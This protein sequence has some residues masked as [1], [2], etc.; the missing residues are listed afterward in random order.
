MMTHLSPEIRPTLKLAIPL[1]IAFLGQQLITIVDTFVSGQLGVEVLAAV[2]LGNALYWMVTIFPIGLLMGLDPIISQALG[3]RQYAL[4]WRACRRGIGLALILSTLTTAVLMISAIEGWP[5][6]PS[7]PVSEHLSAYIWGRAWCVPLVLM[8]TCLRS[9]L[10]AHERGGVILVGTVISNILNLSLSVYLS[11]GDALFSRIFGW[12]SLET[13]FA[14]WGT[15]GIGIASTIVLAVDVSFLSWVAWRMQRPSST[16]SVL[17]DQ[18]EDHDQESIPSLINAWRS[19]C[20]IGA[21]IGG[22]MLSEGGVFCLSTLLVSV[23]STVSIGAHQIVLQLCSTSFMICLGIA[24][25]TCVRVGLAFGAQDRIRA[26]ATALVGLSLSIM[27]MLCSA[28]IFMTWGRELAGILTIDQEVISLCVKLLWIVVI[29]QIFDGIQTTVAAALRGAGY[30]RVPLISA[31]ISHW[32][33]GLPLGLYL[34]F[35]LKLE[36]VGIWW[37]LSG[38]LICAAIILTS[39][40]FWLT[41]AR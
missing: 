5:W 24:S 36:V 31:V 41:R 39:S 7:G 18:T 16:H 13:G 22:S 14:G 28:I 38:G 12:N 23:W 20:R 21:P 19:L 8:H 34:A 4:A 15:I 6:S 35:G 32:G 29:F 17:E 37:G 25:A 40:F 26:R 27:V 33:V 1:V 9:F 3:T 11:G 2:S 10:Q 30:T